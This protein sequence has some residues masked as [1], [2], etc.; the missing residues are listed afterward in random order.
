MIIES[1]EGLSE[2]IKKRA[3][4]INFNL[5]GPEEVQYGFGRKI[6]GFI[7]TLILPTKRD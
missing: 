5:H 6:A 7:F 4:A 3:E 1:F 2:D